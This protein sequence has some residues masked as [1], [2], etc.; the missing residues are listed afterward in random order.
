MAAKLQL[1]Q[2]SAFSN[3]PVYQVGSDVV[4]GLRRTVIPPDPTDFIVQVTQGLIGR[5]DLIAYE[6]YGSVELWW[7]IAEANQ[8]VDPLTEV[9]LGY[10]LIMPTANRV[11]HILGT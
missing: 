7:V 6:V 4:F 2:N 10:E 8:I 3:T 1:K 11:K 9:T 5:L